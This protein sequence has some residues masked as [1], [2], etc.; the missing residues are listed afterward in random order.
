[1]RILLALF[2]AGAFFPIRVVAWSAAGHEVIAAIAYRELPADTKA[3]VFELL[4]SHPE[5]SK[6]QESFEREASTVDL[7]TFVFMKASRWPDE[8]RR[9]GNK[10]DHPKWHYVD[11]ELKP[12]SFPM[13]EEPAPNDNVIYGLAQ[14][15][16][17][18][19][20]PKASPE[21]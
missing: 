8:I 6:W 15:E 4:K 7:P 14:C 17:V 12:P 2:A 20:D 21:E 16:K 9:H 3:K 13:T 1:M 10:Y 18:L 19:R 5:F 11:W